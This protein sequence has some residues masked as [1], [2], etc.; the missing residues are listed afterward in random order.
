MDSEDVLSVLSS[1]ERGLGLLEHV[2]VLL[3]MDSEDVLSVLSSI[4]RGLGLLNI[5]GLSTFVGL[6]LSLGHSSS[7]ES[8]GLVRD[9][10]TTI[11]S[12]LESSKD[13]VTGSGSDETNIKESLEGSG[14]VLS[15]DNVVDITINLGVTGVFIGKLEAGEE[16]SGSE[17]TNTVSSSIVGTSSVESIVGELLGISVDHDTVTL[18][19]GMDDLADDSLVGSSDNESVLSGVVLVLVLEDQSTSGVVIGLSLSSTSEF[20]LV[21]HRVRLVLQN[22]NV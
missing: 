1:I 18:E 6:D 19:G 5:N 11:T 12:T 9:V 17:E 2:I 20:G 10:K 14:R 22:L 7:R 13:T 3:N 8:L 21:P 16:S 4:E 15:G